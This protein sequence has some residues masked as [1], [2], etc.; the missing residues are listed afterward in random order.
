MSGRQTALYSKMKKSKKAMLA[1]YGKKLFVLRKSVQTKHPNTDEYVRNSQLFIFLKEKY[2]NTTVRSFRSLFHFHPF[3]IDTVS[4]RFDFEKYGITNE[5]IVEFF[6]HLSTYSSDDISHM[7]LGTSRG[8]FSNR[9][10]D[11]L[12]CMN[13]QN[14]ISF[15]KRLWDIWP[16]KY[17]HGVYHDTVFTCQTDG[18]ECPVQKTSTDFHQSYLNY[19][20]YWSDCTQKYLFFFSINTGILIGMNGPLYGPTGDTTALEISGVNDILKREKELGIGDCK[21]T[22]PR[23]SNFRVKKDYSKENGDRESF[24]EKRP[25]VENG[26]GMLKRFAIFNMPFRGEHA[27][28]GLFVRAISQFIYFQTLYYPLREYPSQ[29][30]DKDFKSC[31]F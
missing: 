18:T 17:R 23:A 28:Q 5:H 20:G 8:T 12:D 19:S 11:F 10:Q 26:I 31:L 15:E 6:F 3:V 16:S 25:L 14:Y 13:S 30:S 7:V 22:G 21:F 2:P 4:K 27:K 24:Q 9:I 29:M 1:E